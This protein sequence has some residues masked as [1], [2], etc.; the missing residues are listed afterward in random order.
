MHV[1]GVRVRHVHIKPALG[2]TPYT[3]TEK[4]KNKKENERERRKK[5]DKKAKR[6]REREKR[7]TP[8]THKSDQDTY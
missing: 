2:K 7:E 8:P 1:R 4:I 3:C 6:K 5:K